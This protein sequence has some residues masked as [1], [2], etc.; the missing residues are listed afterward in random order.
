MRALTWL[1]TIR[2]LD[3]KTNARVMVRAAHH[4]DVPWEQARKILRSALAPYGL[5]KPI[6]QGG[7]RESLRSRRRGAILQKRTQQVPCFQQKTAQP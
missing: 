7:I 4:W 5:Q 6:W 1:H 3:E 2:Q